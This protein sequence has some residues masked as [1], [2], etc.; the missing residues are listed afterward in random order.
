VIAG[1]VPNPTSGG[2][3]LTAWTVTKHLIGQGHAV[4]VCVV[5]DAPYLDPLG[6]QL[7]DHAAELRAAGADVRTVVSRSSEAMAVLPRSLATRAHRVFRPRDVELYPHLA[8]REAVR[9]TIATLDPD[10][11]FVYHFEALAAT[12]GL[13][14]PRFAA[15]GDPSH[16]PL[17]YRWRASLPSASA[18]RALPRVQVRARAQPRVL[19]RMLNECQGCGAFAAHHAAQLRTLGVSGCEYLHTPVPDPG[20]R[21]LARVPE[22]KPRVLL[23]GHLKGIATL[24]GLRVFATKTL[25]VLERELGADGFEVRV[26]GGFEPPSELRAALDRPSV[27]LLGHREDAAGEIRSADVMIVPTSIPLGIRV[28]VL[29]GFSYGARLVVHRA[30]ALGIPELEHDRNALLG[31]SG[32]ELAEQAIRLIRDESL[33]ARIEQ[34]ARDT[35]ER[36]F[37][38]EVAG[39]H[40]ESRLLEL[41]RAPRPVAA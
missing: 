27:R 10:V 38:P 9:A 24:D 19:A 32:G 21:A 34:G 6:A 13:P 18:I 37:A 3:A 2:G 29:T 25:P 35:Y 41:A 17:L 22:A 28:R 14:Y 36:F 26:V 12:S 23:I 8:D 40:I 4:T 5:H 1:G 7:E 16:L 30:N 11:V 33:R 39:A 31:A 20:L 15:V